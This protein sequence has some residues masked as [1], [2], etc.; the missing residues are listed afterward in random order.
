MKSVILANRLAD[1]TAKAYAGQSLSV[2]DLAEQYRVSSKN[3]T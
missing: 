1:I 3:N 2:N